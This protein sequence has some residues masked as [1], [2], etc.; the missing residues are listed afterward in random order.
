LAELSVDPND[1]TITVATEDVLETDGEPNI[2]QG[3]W[4]DLSKDEL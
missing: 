3:N 4:V 1:A 2:V